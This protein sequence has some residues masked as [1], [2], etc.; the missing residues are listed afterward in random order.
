MAYGWGRESLAE[1]REYAEDT[2]AEVQAEME[3]SGGSSA[4]ARS[5]ARGRKAEEAA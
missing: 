3:H 5:R 4:G 1:M 2:Y